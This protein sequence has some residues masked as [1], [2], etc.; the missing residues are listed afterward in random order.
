MAWPVSSGSWQIRQFR[1][2]ALA[3]TVPVTKTFEVYCDPIAMRCLQIEV[4]VFVNKG[5]IDTIQGLLYEQV[6][7]S[8][9]STHQSNHWILGLAALNLKQK[10]LGAYDRTPSAR[11]GSFAARKNLGVADS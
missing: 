10:S 1:V 3:R 4:A 8:Y 2:R 9:P 7:S 5:V 11:L 6:I